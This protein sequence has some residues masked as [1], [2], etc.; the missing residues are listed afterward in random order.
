[1]IDTQI[2]LLL[3]KLPLPSRDKFVETF[4]IAGAELGD[5]ILSSCWHQY[6]LNGDKGSINGIHWAESTSNATLLNSTLRILSKNRWIIV[7]SVPK[8]RWSDIKINE[9]K[10]LE[11]LTPDELMSVR[12]HKKFV[13]YMP[14]FDDTPSPTNLTRVN[15]K[16]RS[17]GLIRYGF[18]AA[19]DTQYYYDIETLRKYADPIAMNVVKGMSKC[20]ELWT[21]MTSIE[22]DYDAISIDIVNDLASTPQLMTI[23]NNTSDSR[24]RAIKSG[25]S[26]VAN[27][28]GYKDFR[29]LLSIPVGY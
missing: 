11:Y 3:G 12:K 16:V 4:G 5:S 22:A 14:T 27:P 10:L 24:G 13:K 19:K 25:L 28:I 18:A 21:D 6:L 29:A 23:G 26:K 9:S 1:M 2:A 15:G 17:T 7:T 8:Y 20:R